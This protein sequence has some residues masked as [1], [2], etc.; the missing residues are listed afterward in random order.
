MEPIEVET[1]GTYS[2]SDGKLVYSGLSFDWDDFRQTCTERGIDPLVA[3]ATGFDSLSR[4]IAQN[5]N[6]PTNKVENIL[7]GFFSWDSGDINEQ[8]I[9]TILTILKN[10]AKGEAR[11]F[12]EEYIVEY[13]ARDYTRLSEKA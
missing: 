9:R 6:K 5:K 10:S 7:T 4:T 11:T 8:N 3:A 1:I 13:A 12:D 2:H